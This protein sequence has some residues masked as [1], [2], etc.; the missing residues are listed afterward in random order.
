[1][2]LAHTNRAL[3]ALW[4]PYHLYLKVFWGKLLCPS[5]LT[6]LLYY[7]P[8]HFFCTKITTIWGSNNPAT[9][10]QDWYI[11]MRPSPWTCMPCALANCGS[12]PSRIATL[13]WPGS[14]APVGTRSAALVGSRYCKGLSHDPLCRVRVLI[15]PRDAPFSAQDTATVTSSAELA[16]VPAPAL[17]RAS[18][19]LP[20]AKNR[21]RR[22]QRQRK[23]LWWRERKGDWT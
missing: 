3:E 20:G 13:W 19:P 16:Q 21:Y 10:L 1:M 7:F 2:Y 17:L 18:S 14:P 15:P 8:F 22:K 23:V 12:T 9:Q 5:T 4:L 6:T 11:S